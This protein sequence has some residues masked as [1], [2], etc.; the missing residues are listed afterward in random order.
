MFVDEFRRT[1]GFIL[2]VEDLAP[3]IGVLWW[4]LIHLQ[5]IVYEIVF[6]FFFRCVR[7]FTSMISL[8]T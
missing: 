4:V 5:I 1:Y 6:F 2:T 8:P 3:N 7:L